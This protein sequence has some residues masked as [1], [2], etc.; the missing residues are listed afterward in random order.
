MKGGTY[1]LGSQ[2]AVQSIEVNSE[3]ADL[4]I[5]L[6]VACQAEPI[7]TKH[8]IANADYLPPDLVESDPSA[9]ESEART[10]AHVIAVLPSIPECL[11]R[12]PSEEPAVE[13]GISQ[14]SEQDDTAIVVFPPEEGRGL[15]R[16]LLMGDGTGSCPPGQC[17][18]LMT[19]Q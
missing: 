15:V 8:I 16:A 17:A 14:D 3:D 11:R 9:A 1:V 6:S 19:R 10:A 2:G 18:S 4:P 5:K 7:H 13:G 12:S